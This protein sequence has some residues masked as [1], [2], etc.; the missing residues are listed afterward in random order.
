[1]E[2]LLELF[3][4]ALITISSLIFTIPLFLKSSREE[5]IYPKSD[6]KY[7]IGY[8]FI[9]LLGIFASLFTLVG[10]FD[11]TGSVFKFIL[12]IFLICL[13][14]LIPYFFIF[15]GRNTLK[16]MGKVKNLIIHELNP[17]PF[18]SREIRV[19]DT[20]EKI[21]D[22]S[23]FTLQTLGDHNYIALNNG[24]DDF[25]VISKMIT[26][27]T[28]I[29]PYKGN[30]LIKEIMR[31]LRNLSIACIECKSDEYSRKTGKHMCK[32]ITDGLKN[33]KEFEY[34]NLVLN[35]KKLGI[36]AAKKCLEET[37]DEILNNL[38][39][40]GDQSIKERDI[41]LFPTSAVL[42]SLQNIGIVCT[43][44]KMIH[45]CATARTRLLA[46][47]RL[48]KQLEQED[49]LHKALRRFW[50]VTAYLYIKM[51]EMEEAKYKLETLLKKEFGSVF[52]QTID[53]AIEMLHT[54]GEWAQKRIVKKFKN[55]SKFFNK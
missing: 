27:G 32:I 39:Q 36:E 28:K 17:I 47:A 25:M 12:V 45:Q 15:L 35:V 29:E 54:E 11:L 21:N 40:I 16:L 55:T 20:I 42:K 30:I 43:K 13:I 37:T 9:F 10:I 31:T 1:M 50:V 26:Q 8:L 5:V 53:E 51:P 4:T 18:I 44:E 3:I 23:R 7:L 48:G 19:E 41:L 49:V 2:S 24:I 52:I 34:L 38:G 22:L 33:Q 6:E 14:L 46:T